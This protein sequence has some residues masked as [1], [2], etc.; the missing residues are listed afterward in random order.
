M[1]PSSSSSNSEQ[2]QQQHLR[3]PL[4]NRKKGKKIKGY[5]HGRPFFYLNNDEKVCNFLSKVLIRLK[6]LL[7]TKTV[8]DKLYHMRACHIFLHNC[9]A[10]SGINPTMTNSE[11]QMNSRIS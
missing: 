4:S 2:Q 8:V 5:R 7:L 10:K 9:F 3:P 11:L 6:L 1:K